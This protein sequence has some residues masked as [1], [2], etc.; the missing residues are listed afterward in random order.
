VLLVFLVGVVRLLQTFLKT[1][2]GIGKS[3]RFVRAIFYVLHFK[4]PLRIASHIA[5]EQEPLSVGTFFTKAILWSKLEEMTRNKIL[6]A[7]CRER[8]KPAIIRAFPDIF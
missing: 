6:H 3:H 2:E 8:E 4:T 1:V 5:D 7:G